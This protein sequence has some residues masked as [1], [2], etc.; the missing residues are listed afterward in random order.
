[1]VQ[2]TAVKQSKQDLVVESDE[3]QSESEWKS[4]SQSA[5]EGE[6]RAAKT[7]F[8]EGIFWRP[9]VSMPNSMVKIKPGQKR[10]ARKLIKSSL[11][12]ANATVKTNQE[13]VAVSHKAPSPNKS[14][15]GRVIK[16]GKNSKQL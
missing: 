3:S 2:D 6:N 16:P 1:M 5:S 9:T 13:E 8:T 15:C 14:R 11:A 7:K 4:A 12:K 10:P